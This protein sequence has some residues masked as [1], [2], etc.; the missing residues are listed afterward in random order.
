MTADTPMFK[1]PKLD[2]RMRQGKPP[3]PSRDYDRNTS[4]QNRR[5]E[6]VP[7]IPLPF[8]GFRKRCRCGARFWTLIGYRAHYALEHI[9]GMDR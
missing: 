5:G 3:R 4:A 9:L 2:Q 7:S 6:W 8:F 1:A